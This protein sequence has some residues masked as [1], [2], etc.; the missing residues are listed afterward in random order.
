MTKS[1]NIILSVTAFLAILV[2][3]C[4]EDSPLDGEQYMKQVSIVGAD[5]TTNEGLRVVEVPYRDLVRSETSVSVT[6][7]GSLNIDRDIT[8]VLKEAGSA[9][10]DDYN[11]K[12]LDDDEPQYRHLDDEAYAIPDLSVDIKAGEVYGLM[13]VEISTDGLNA[14]SLYAL[15]FQIES[16]SDPEYI[17]VRPVDTVL[18]LAFKLINDF[19]GLYKSQGY[20][21]PY[22]PDTGIATGDS[23]EISTSRNLTALDVHTVRLFHLLSVESSAN[24]SAFVLSLKIEDDNSVVVR[25]WDELVLIDGAGTYAPSTQTISYWYIYQSGTDVRKFTGTLKRTN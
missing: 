1:S 16:V 17:S 13:P 6:T 8:V 5:Q 7:G 10:I 3:G 9:T 2:S 24:R 14:D 19:S 12:Y 23:S 21:F 25:P 22:D 11:F 20:D 18:I 4:R 15:T